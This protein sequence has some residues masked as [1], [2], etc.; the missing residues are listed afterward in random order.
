MKGP[1]VVV[2]TDPSFGDDALVERI[3]AAL[4]GAPAGTVAVQ[5][6]DKARD[7]AAVYALAVRL[8]EVTAR[9]GAGLVVN[10]RLDVALAVGADGV[11]LGGGAVAVGDARA[12]LGE[13]AWISVAAHAVEEVVAAAREGADAVLV[14]PVFATPGKGEGRGVAA[15]A[16]AR[17]AV[18][19]GVEVIALGGVNEGN[20]GECVAAGAGGV[21]VVRAVLGAGAAGEVVRRLVEVVGAV[22]R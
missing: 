20:A 6:R 16:E 18:G 2:I 4:A 13:G 5:L 3:D 7:G 10:D 12:L 11:H 14:S 15:I 8:R 17:G 9:Y 1:R 22:G 21:A 19:G